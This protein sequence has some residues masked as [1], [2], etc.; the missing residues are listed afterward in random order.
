MQ[1][2][3]HACAPG[4]REKLGN[5]WV[6]AK[7]SWLNYF[8]IWRHLIDPNFGKHY[9]T[10]C[11]NMK[12]TKN[13]QWGMMF[14]INNYYPCHRGPQHWWPQ[15]QIWPVGHLESSTLLYKDR[16]TW[17]L[18]LLLDMCI[19]SNNQSKMYKYGNCFLGASEYPGLGNVETE[20]G[21]VLIKDAI[22]VTQPLPGI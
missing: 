1:G 16:N 20:G 9:M 19:M 17:S 10:I 7:P 6:K 3:T 2:Y 5:S 15:Q 8:G 13:S 22:V 21:Q 4:Y 12:K 18:S 11:W 14:K